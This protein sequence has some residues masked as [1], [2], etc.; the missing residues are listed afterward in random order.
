MFSK[1]IKSWNQY[2]FVAKPLHGLVLF[3]IG[4]ALILFAYYLKRLPY[5]EM[6]FSVESFDHRLGFIESLSIPLF[7]P[8]VA[9]FLVLFCL[10]TSL[11]FALGLWT[12]L[13]NIFL[14]VLVAYLG[15]VEGMYTIGGFNLLLIS[16]FLLIFSDCGKYGS[17][18]YWLWLKKGNKKKKKEIEKRKVGSYW[19][20]RLIVVQLAIVYL[21]CA[22]YKSQYAY[23]WYNGK[24]LRETLL[25]P[26]WGQLPLG[27][28]MSQYHWVMAF[29]GTSVLLWEFFMS[30]FVLL[31]KFRNFAFISGVFFHAF[32]LFTFNLTSLFSFTMFVH[33]ILVLSPYDVARYCESFNSFLRKNGIGVKK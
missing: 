23:G 12:R 11:L 30:L 22:F 32:I 20:Q 6:I 9:M 26:Y 3:R 25:D 7:S 10:V 28:W 24:F 19:V 4:V 27:V 13:S 16:S 33:L 8:A 31:P 21:A 18:D 2:W 5:A 14:V 15:C 1:W 17:L 29:A